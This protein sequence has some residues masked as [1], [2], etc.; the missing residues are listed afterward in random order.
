[1]SKKDSP[2]CFR[3]LSVPDDLKEYQPGEFWAEGEYESPDD[4]VRQCEGTY[5]P[6]TNRF[7]CTECY[8]EIG[9]PSSAGYPGWKA[10]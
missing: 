6:V 4:Y 1:M 2:Y 5:N 10:P 3:C 7:A 8:I 9:M